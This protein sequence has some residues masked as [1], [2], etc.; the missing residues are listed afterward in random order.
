MARIMEAIS[1]V[2][3]IDALSIEEVSVACEG[4]ALITPEGPEL[5]MD[6]PFGIQLMDK[7]TDEMKATLEVARKGGSTKSDPE[8]TFSGAPTKHMDDGGTG[9]GD[10]QQASR[11]A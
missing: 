3:I 5:L 6:K 10:E 8:P 4:I 1:P 7:T 11:L 9:P 2:E